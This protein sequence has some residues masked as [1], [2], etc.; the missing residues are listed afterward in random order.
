MGDKMEGMVRFVASRSSANLPV[1][2]YHSDREPFCAA[3]GQVQEQDA[4]LGLWR[5]HGCSS[6]RLQEG[7]LPL[8][9]SYG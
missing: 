5:G 1:A 6:S 7:A 4:Q 9:F 8:C 3:S 2:A